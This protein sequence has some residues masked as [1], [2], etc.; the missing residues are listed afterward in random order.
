MVLFVK[1]VSHFVTCRKSNPAN[2]YL[3][4][5]NNKNARKRCEIYSKLSIKALEPRHHWSPENIKKPSG[6]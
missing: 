5:I 3:V 2:I 4:K 6:K 1:D